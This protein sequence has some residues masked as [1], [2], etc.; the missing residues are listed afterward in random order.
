MAVEAL[1]RCGAAAASRACCVELMAGK[2]SAQKKMPTH[3]ATSEPVPAANS[4]SPANVEARNSASVTCTKHRD[5][6]ACNGN[7]DNANYAVEREKPAGR[8][9]TSAG[10][11]FEQR[12]EIEGDSGLPGRL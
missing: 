3:T 4:T 2:P 1:A 5:D 12:R 11:T 7:A 9:R 6:S 8:L 10:E